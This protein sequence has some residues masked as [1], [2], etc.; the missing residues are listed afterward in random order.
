MKPPKKEIHVLNLADVPVE[1]VEKLLKVNYANEFYTDKYRKQHVGHILPMPPD[2]N[3][4]TR[5]FLWIKNLV[6]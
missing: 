4:F 1:E 2:Q 3:L 6:S 5:L